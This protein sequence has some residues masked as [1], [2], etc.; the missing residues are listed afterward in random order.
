MNNLKTKHILNKILLYIIVIAIM[1]LLLLPILGL[2][3]STF[4]E[5]TSEAAFKLIMPSS[6]SLI[7]FLRSLLLSL[8]ISLTSLFIAFLIALGLYRKF[9]RYTFLVNGIIYLSVFMLL[10]PS[11]VHAQGWWRFFDI[12]GIHTRGI[13]ISWWVSTMYYLPLPTVLIYTSLKAIEQHVLEAGAVFLKPSKM[14]LGVILPTLYPVMFGSGL[15]VF[16]LSLGDYS[17][18][19]IFSVNVYSLDITAQ[20]SVSGSVPDALLY[21]LPLVIVGLIVGILG[22]KTLQGLSLTSKGTKGKGYELFE[23]PKSVSIL[24]GFAFIIL[25]GSIFVP[26]IVMTISLFD[27]SDML[28]YMIMSLNEFQNT[29]IVSLSTLLIT[30]PISLILGSLINRRRLNYIIYFTIAIPLILPSSLIGIGLIGIFKNT[31]VYNTVLMTILASVIRFTPIGTILCYTGIKSLN[32][33]TLLAQ[34]IYQSSP[35]NGFMRLYLPMILPY[36]LMGGVIAA[37]LSTGEIGATIMITPPGFNT[38]AIKIYNYLHYGVS[39]AVS[40]LCGVLIFFSFIIS[41]VVLYGILKTRGGK[42]S[43]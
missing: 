19:S 3:L 26:F 28:N 25:I 4:L 10:L 27:G 11:F 31:I 22:I 37:I 5:G 42:S 34:S 41:N 8:M 9:D 30:G 36:T 24:S 15:L 18:P 20:F 6:R 29:M 13:I 21:S 2:L 16:L 23:I 17:I 38:L 1:T 7:L 33:E 40:V 14:L 12:V 39:N 43:G 32:Q 35:L